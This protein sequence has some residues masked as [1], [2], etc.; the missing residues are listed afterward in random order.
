MEDRVAKESMNICHPDIQK[1][2]VWENWYTTC[3]VKIQ[4]YTLRDV[5]VYI[6][7][8]SSYISVCNAS[9]FDILQWNMIA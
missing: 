2:Q 5:L 4:R 1:E 9:K 3:Y 6:T 8:N 7:R